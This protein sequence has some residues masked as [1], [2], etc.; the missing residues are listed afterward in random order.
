MARRRSRLVSVVPH[1]LAL[2]LGLAAAPGAAAPVAEGAPPTLSD[3][4]ACA[5]FDLHHVTNLEDHGGAGE[6]DPEA[7][8]EAFLAVV[9]ARGLC[10]AGRAGEGLALY[11]DLPLA[12]PRARRFR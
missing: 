3:L 8:A 12:P 1:G 7:M 4:R 6:L 2:V 9:R 11:A 5:A 10:R